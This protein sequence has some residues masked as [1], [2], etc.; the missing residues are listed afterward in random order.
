MKK[1]EYL[2]K[3]GSASRVLQIVR[4]LT[5]Y[6]AP[7]S[8][9]NDLFEF[10]VQSLY[11]ESADS[12]YRVFAK[13]LIHEGRFSTVDEALEGIKECNLETDA[14]EMYELFLQQLN[15]FLADVMRYSG[16][17][18]FSEERNNQRMWGTYGDN[19]AG[20]AIEFTTAQGSSSF[21]AHLNPVLY[22]AKKIGICPSEFMTSSLSVDTWLCS[23]M[24]CMKHW[25]WRDEREWRLL[26][27]ANTEQTTAERIVRFERSA[28][29]RIFLGP[30][31]SRSNEDEIRSAATQHEPNIPVL[32]RR[33]DDQEAKE[34]YVGVEEIRSFDQLIYWANRLAK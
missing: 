9:L 4:D 7:V 17:T 8:Q 2:Y 34:E 12:R 33:V 30:R 26:L 14:T 11:T 28:I 25:H 21:A 23:V 16:V 18:C 15:S 10:R 29:T 20:A 32:K 5:F 24:C 27:L 13:R 6:F 31:I 22:L 3:Y 19:H 1:P